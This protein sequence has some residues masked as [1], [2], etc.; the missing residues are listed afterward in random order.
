MGNHREA[1]KNTKRESQSASSKIRNTKSEA[2]NA[3]MNIDHFSAENEPHSFSA[4]F[5]NS[6]RS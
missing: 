5:Q 2:R 1:M 4:N 3:E 6:K